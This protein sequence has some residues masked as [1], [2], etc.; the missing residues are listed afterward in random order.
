MPSE[1]VLTSDETRYYIRG[2]Y[3][4]VDDNDFANDLLVTYFAIPDAIS[5]V[6]TRF[7]FGLAG[8]CANTLI[9]LPPQEDPD[10]TSMKVKQSIARD[11]WLNCVR[12]AKGF[13]PVT[14]SRNKA[15]STSMRRGWI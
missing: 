15:T 8:Y 9:D 12:L 14:E 3:L 13:R 4:F 10:F 7:H 1:D 11:I 5:D 6:P 2:A